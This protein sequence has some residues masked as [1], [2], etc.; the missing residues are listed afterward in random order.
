MHYEHYTPLELKNQFKKLA[1]QSPTTAIERALQKL[2]SPVISPSDRQHALDTAGLLLENGFGEETICA[3]L[4]KPV[5]DDSLTHQFDPQIIELAKATQKISAVLQKNADLVPSETLSKLLIAT[6][7]DIRAIVIQLARALTELRFASINP[8]NQEKAKIALNVL[9][10]LSAKLGL[11][12]FRWELEDLS[13]KQLESETY[14][15]LKRQLN[16]KRNA[17]QE[18]AKTFEAKLKKTLLKH[19][20]KT[21][22]FSR[23]KNLYRIHK[24]MQEQNKTISEINDLIA[25]RV[26]CNTVA[27][28]YQI[29]STIQNE[30]EE[31]PGGYSDYIAKP[32]KTGYQSLHIDILWEKKPYEVQIRTWNMHKVAENG[33]AAHWQYK[34]FIRD[35]K[36]DPSLSVAKQI[37]EWISQEKNNDINQNLFI[38]FD[39]NQILVLTPKYDLVELP[40]NSTCLDFAFAVHSQLGQTC[41]KTKINGKLVPLNHTLETG[42]VVEIITNPHQTPKR[43]WLAFVKTDKAKQKIRGLLSLQRE[44]KPL[45][46]AKKI[47]IQLS[48]KHRHHTILAKCCSPLPGDDVIGYKTTK[49]KITIHRSDCQNMKPVSQDKKIALSNDQFPK[50]EFETTLSIKTDQNPHTIADILNH[51]TKHKYKIIGTTT[52]TES[53]GVLCEFNLKTKNPQHLEKTLFEIK[54]IKGV[55]SAKRE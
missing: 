3:C 31:I 16:E 32:K 13:F 55:K 29:A 17:R 45:V 52:K 33:I 46:K 2:E 10:P 12:Q 48:K 19:Q 1:L 22:V 4:I 54:K 9:V 36:F 38:Q 18:K 27:E 24:K 14:S 47:T 28:C 37:T 44:N 39:K 23:V 26:I 40:R 15:Q 49:R 35:P 11:Q 5:L 51:L 41:E 43:Q 7:K 30:F 34:Q 6:A 53:G 21:L 50:G 20:F 25:S 8:A 42:D